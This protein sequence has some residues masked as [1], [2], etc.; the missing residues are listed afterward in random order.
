MITFLPVL[1]E[2]RYNID[3]VSHVIFCLVMIYKFLWSHLLYCSKTRRYRVVHHV[4][5]T[6]RWLHETQTHRTSKF[7][8]IF[9][10][11]KTLESFYIL[12]RNEWSD[13][14]GKRYLCREQPYRTFNGERTRWRYAYAQNRQ[15]GVIRT[16]GWSRTTW[17][18]CSCFSLL[19]F[20]NLSIFAYWGELVKLPWS[21]SSPQEAA[22]L[23]AG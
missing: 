21:L 19:Q 5:G 14:C 6:F 13:S 12:E 2:N 23:R 17:N 20:N 7:N 16:Q 22:I 9:H 3:E 10:I 18:H 8:S 4:N 15:N 11:P 1:S